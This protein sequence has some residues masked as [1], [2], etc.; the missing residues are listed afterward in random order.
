[1]VFCFHSVTV[2][3]SLCCRAYKKA[4][5]H[6]NI[7]GDIIESVN[8]KEVTNNNDLFKILDLCKEG[9]KL[10]S[11]D[12]APEVQ[13]PRLRWLSVRRSASA[14]F[15]FFSDSRRLGSIRADVARFVPNRLRF[16]PNR[17]NSAKIGLYRPY[18]VVSAGD[19][20]SQNM[21]ETAEIDLEYGWKSRN[22]PSSFFLW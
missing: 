4:N 14:F 15:F 2:D 18:R 17:A 5:H 20:Y 1:M 13:H 22:L 3:Q 7:L 19:R 12:A 9:D 16:A 10:E 21:P 11:T 8:G 6:A